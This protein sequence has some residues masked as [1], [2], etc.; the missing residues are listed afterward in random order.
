MEYYVRGDEILHFCRLMEL[1]DIMSTEIS[2]R[3][4]KNVELS[5]PVVDRETMQGNR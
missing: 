5:Y 1:N 2:Q 3:E 4:K